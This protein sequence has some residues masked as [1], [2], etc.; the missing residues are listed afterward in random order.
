DDVAFHEVGAIDSIVDIVGTAAAL[1]WL[2]PVSVTAAS[3]AV[4]HG[5]VKCAHGLLPVP[6]PATLEILRAAGGRAHG[7]GLGRELCTPTGAAILASAVTAWAPM[8]FMVPVAAGYGAG[9]MDFPDRPNIMRAT[10]G[11]PAQ[12]PDMS[13]GAGSVWRIEANI[14]DMS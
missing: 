13:A 6:A 3:V 14:D 4:G 1:A 10:V 7:G 9:D 2:A 11:R 5:A 8:P 12:A